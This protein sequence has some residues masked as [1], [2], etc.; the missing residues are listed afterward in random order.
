MTKVKQQKEILEQLKDGHTIL[1]P[2]RAEEICEVFQIRPSKRLIKNHDVGR[3]G[4]SNA[5]DPTHA[6]GV[7]DLK[8]LYYIA[9]KKGIDSTNE[10]VGRGSQAQA[11]AEKIAA[12]LQ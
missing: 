11:V 10:F 9:R 4:W 5:R 12:T 7:W 6:K 2:R 1:T 3:G 8:L